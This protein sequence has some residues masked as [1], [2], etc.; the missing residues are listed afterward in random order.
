MKRKLGIAAA[1]LLVLVLS[2]F[3]W[4]KWELASLKAQ[5]E[6]YSLEALSKEPDGIVELIPSSDGALIRAVSKGSGRTVV[7]VHGLSQNMLEW[8][9]LWPKLVEAGY[10][11]IAVDLRGHGKS[12][13]GSDGMTTA[14]MARD[15]AQ[16]LE[17]Y[18][19]RDGI[20]VGHS[21]GGFIAS[22]FLTEQ[23]KVAN[24]RLGGA[25]LV[26]TFAGTILQGSPGWDPG[27]APPD[28]TWKESVGYAITVGVVRSGFLPWF[29]QTD[30]GHVLS[31]GM[32]GG[33]PNYSAIHV[34][35][36]MMAHHD[37]TRALPIMKASYLEDYYPKLRDVR[38]PCVAIGGDADT[39][40]R[41]W[42]IER[43]ARD[44][45][46]GRAISVPGVGHLI[47]WEAPDALVEAIR[48]LGPS[49]GDSHVSASPSQPVP[50]PR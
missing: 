7:L 42:H 48:S 26:A 19:V 13:V 8:S 50:S 45:P 39:A 17:H 2:V 11:V 31:R 21:L 22:V 20:L 4:I 14:A 32:M 33:K 25:V 29:V 6:P 38:I 46:K 34:A 40:V 41:P 5:A 47:N 24:E 18:D 36:Q 15:V 1:A 12:T 28:G 43:L 3:I 10:R 30:A 37:S 27:P 16:I 35:L 9:V 49:T 23:S 44:I